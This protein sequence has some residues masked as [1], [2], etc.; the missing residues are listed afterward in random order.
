[1]RLRAHARVDV[2]GGRERDG[3]RG[4]R[5][6]R[7]GRRREGEGGV[8]R[9][10][11]RRLLAARDGEHVRVRADALDDLEA[12]GCVRERERERARV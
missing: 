10:V 5:G 3:P 9:G 12:G 7:R 2:E 11:V 6:A 8:G 1:M 4:R